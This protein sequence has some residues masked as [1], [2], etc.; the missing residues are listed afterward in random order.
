MTSHLSNSTIT[1]RRSGV[2]DKESHGQ[3]IKDNFILPYKDVDLPEDESQIV[4][5]QEFA[6]IGF[7]NMKAKNKKDYIIS[8]FP[9]KL[10]A[11]LYFAWCKDCSENITPENAKYFRD[12]L[13]MRK[14]K[15]FRNYNFRGMR[16]AKN[17]VIAFVGNID[18][19]QINKLDLSDNLITDVCMHNLKNIISSKRCVSLNLASNMI[20]TE[21]LKIVQNEIINS[22][23]LTYLNVIYFNSVRNS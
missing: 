22:E 19:T 12:E 23:S 11:D 1:R 5:T 10:F 20:S 14:N 2:K 8:L 6:N 4:L 15:D 7:E 16:I 21:G 18:N 3:Q 17:F 9:R 13:L